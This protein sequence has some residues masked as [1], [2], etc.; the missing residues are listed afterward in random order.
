MSLSLQEKSIQEKI[1][2]YR[3][4]GKGYESI[5]NEL[6]KKAYQYTKKKY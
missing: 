3:E 4:N 5:I 1:R 6:S 2:D